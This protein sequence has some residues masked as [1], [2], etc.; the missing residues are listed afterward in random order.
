MCSSLPYSQEMVGYGKLLQK[1]EDESTLVTSV[2][3]RFHGH[4]LSYQK[5]FSETATDL[6][7]ELGFLLSRTDIGLILQKH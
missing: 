1:N 6:E 4:R 3:L 2:S 5:V 7:A